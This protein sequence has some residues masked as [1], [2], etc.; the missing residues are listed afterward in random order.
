MA[1]LTEAKDNYPLGKLEKRIRQADLLIWDEV[2]C[3]IVSN[4]S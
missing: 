4:W 1:E 2:V 3:K